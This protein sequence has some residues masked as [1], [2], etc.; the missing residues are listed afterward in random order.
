M[1]MYYWKRTSVFLAAYA[2]LGLLVTVV[3]TFLSF[4]NMDLSVFAIL[5]T[6]S[7]SVFFLI[8]ES[9][10]FILPFIFY[11]MVLP[12]KKH[13]TKFD[14]WFTGIFFTVSLYLTAFKSIAEYFFWDEF[15]SRFNFIAVDYLVYTNEVIKNIHESYPVIS[16][17]TTAFILTCAAS[18]ALSK[19]FT[20]AKNTAIPK[21]SN[22]LAVFAVNLALCA[23]I[24]F[25][26]TLSWSEVTNNRFNNEIAKGGAYSFVYAFTHN[27][28][29]YDVFYPTLPQ[30]EVDKIISGKIPLGK[31][32][33]RQGEELN[34]NIII[35]LMESMSAKYMERTAGEDNS[36]VTPYLIRY[37]REGVF[38]PNTYATGTR[39]VRGIEALTIA[40][41]PLPGMSI[42]RRNNNENLYTIG[43]IFRKKGYKTEFVYGG[44]GAFDNM[45][46]YFRNNG[47][48]INDRTDFPKNEVRFANAW[49]VSDEDLFVQAIKRADSYH[50]N[51][52]KFFL[53]VLTTSNHRP[54]TFPQNAID[55]PQGERTSAIKYADYSVGQL[56][57]TAKTKPWFDNTVFVFVADHEAGIAGKDELHPRE[58]RIPLIIYA[59][60]LIKPK[61]YTHHISQIDALPTLLSLLNIEYENRFFGQDATAEDYETRYFLINYQKAGF[62]HNDTLT[63]LKPIKHTDFYKLPS[64]EKSEDKQTNEEDFKTAVSFFQKANDWRNLL[65]E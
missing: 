38:F 25:F 18:F 52:E 54:Y 43:T 17:L 24:A 29:E 60:K 41:P 36:P 14:K 27:E 13:N 21:F 34:P 35:V 39:T 55:L 49:G 53:F 5:K 50:D 56:V 51:K 58:H 1:L 63:L 8:M 65:K 28:L 23:V 7:V 30:E 26:T 57:E 10:F 19:F 45:N 40:V 59:P 32:I 46:Y 11:L 64:M 33:S 3:F 62:V 2:A 20:A 15:L 37:A 6:F 22:R 44:Y 48:A 31:F 12:A 9:V 61:T 16:I 42:V 47:F 4:G